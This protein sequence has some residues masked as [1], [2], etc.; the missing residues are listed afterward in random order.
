M[1]KQTPWRNDPTIL[2]RL[3]TVEALHLKGH[4]NVYVAGKLG[5]D[6]KTVRNDLKR[7]QQLWRERVGQDIEQQKER[8]VAVYRQVQSE[9]WESLENAKD[10]SM[11]KPT[12]LNAIKNAE[13]SIT[14]ILG[15]EKPTKI[16]LTDPSGE[17][18]YSG[19]N[20]ADLLREFTS[21]LDAARAREAEQASGD[22]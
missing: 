16:A 10:T 22:N 20:D 1:H 18:E 15:L 14:K 21:L 6:E 17:K 19:L 13:D 12:Y 3:Q 7:I 4:T 8:S 11:V 2:Q 5:V 9:A